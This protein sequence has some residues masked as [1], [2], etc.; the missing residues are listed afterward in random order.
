MKNLTAIILASL[1]LAACGDLPSVDRP[2]PVPTPTPTPTPAPAPTPI[3]A[4]TPDLVQEDIDFLIGEE[5]STRFVLGQPALTRGLSCSV[6]K[7][8]PTSGTCFSNSTNNNPTS[9]SG[10]LSV[11]GAAN[12]FS[13]LGSFSQESLTSISIPN[14]I[15]PSSLRLLYLSERYRIVCSGFLVVREPNYYDFTVKFVGPAI[16]TVNNTIVVNGYSSPSMAEK[17]GAIFLRRGV[18]PFKIEYA[19]TSS[20]FGLSIKAGGEPIESRF[21][22]Q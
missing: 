5:N 17:F 18:V 6:A 11:V 10:T 2:E 9:C 16:L 22:Y 1:I 8:N 15:L 20:D 4:P 13:Y 3:P 7:I 21:F 19:T 12:T 14:P